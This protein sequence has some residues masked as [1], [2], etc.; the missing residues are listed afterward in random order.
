[1]TRDQ[2]SKSLDLANQQWETAHKRYMQLRLSEDDEAMF[3]ASREIDR[4]NRELDALGE[5]A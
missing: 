2:I 1:M 5:M 4:L 3:M